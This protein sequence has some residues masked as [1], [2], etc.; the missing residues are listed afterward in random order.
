MIV[1]AL[2]LAGG[3]G[4]RLG[5]VRKA[6]IRIGGRGLLDRVADRLADLPLLVST[7]PGAGRQIGRG[8]G[9]ADHAPSHDGPMAGIA[10][11]LHH[12]RDRAG[13]DDLLLSV[14][15]DTPFLP[16]DYAERMV[17]ALKGGANAAYAAWGDQIYPTNAIYRL[18]ALYSLAPAAMP[19]SPKRLLK[20]LDARPV[21]WS[22]LASADPFANLNTLA[23]LIALGR[24][25][26]SAGE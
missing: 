18:S 7:G 25:A 24:R 20:S 19:D 6:E 3:R 23:D 22:A 11:A 5:D 16:S 17:G 4:S 9:L 12:L 10:A 8:I 2:I 13:P 21:D 15:V 1:H 14:A 26:L